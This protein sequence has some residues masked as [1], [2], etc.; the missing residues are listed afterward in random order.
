MYKPPVN[1][2]GLP[3]KGALMDQRPR[4]STLWNFKTSD[5]LIERLKR[6]SVVTD[7]P[8]S[9]IVREAIRE[10]LDQL[11]VEFPQIDAATPQQATA[12]N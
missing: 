12:T 6:A 7:R 1:T 10:K 9:Q 8:A 4:K 5:E 11:A 3:A 2:S